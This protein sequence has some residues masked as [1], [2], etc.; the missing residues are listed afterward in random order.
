MTGN[1]VTVSIKIEV[2]GAVTVREAIA[3]LTS[4]D[5]S[6]LVIPIGEAKTSGIVWRTGSGARDS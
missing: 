2:S 4:A 1:G 3:A 5:G 6:S